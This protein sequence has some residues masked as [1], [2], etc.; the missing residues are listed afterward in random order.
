MQFLP[1]TC[2]SNLQISDFSG[3]R[4][5]HQQDLEN[6]T[7]T[8]QPLKT[9]KLFILAVRQYIRKSAAYLLSH[10]I[11]LILLGVIVAIVG[12]L[13]VTV[14]GPHGKVIQDTKFVFLYFLEWL[15]FVL[16]RPSLELTL[17]CLIFRESFSYLSTIVQSL[18]KKPFG[19]IVT[20]DAYLFFLIFIYPAV[21]QHVEEIQRYVQFGLWWVALGVASSIGL[22]MRRPKFFL[23]IVLLYL[24]RNDG[25]T[26]RN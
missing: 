8:S 16:L 5:K 1:I 9:L 18:A 14:D 17:K 20:D 4:E 7:L 23:Q 15:F 12:A 2:F 19:A 11:W 3:L 21:M 24:D 25:V 26:T 13:L 6:L 10:A 22:G